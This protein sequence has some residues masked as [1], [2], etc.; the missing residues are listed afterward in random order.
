[1]VVLGCALLMWSSVLQDALSFTHQGRSLTTQHSA[2]VLYST[3]HACKPNGAAAEQLT[4]QYAKA[5]MPE[6]G[7]WRGHGKS[8]ILPLHSAQAACCSE[9]TQSIQCMPFKGCNQTKQN[10]SSTTD[11]IKCDAYGSIGKTAAICSNA[12]PRFPKQ[13]TPHKQTAQNHHWVVLHIS[14]GGIGSPK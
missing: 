6:H 8:C 1:M 12:G 9:S 11:N 4:N 10:R 7:T 13:R 5:S 3:P 14:T 2:H